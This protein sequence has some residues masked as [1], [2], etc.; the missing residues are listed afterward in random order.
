MNPPAWSSSARSSSTS[1]TSAGSAPRRASHVARSSAGTSSACSSR[2]LTSGQ[3]SRW[4]KKA[5]S[6]LRE[7]AEKEQLR[8]RP[9]ALDRGGGNSEDLADLLIV[10]AGEKP[11]LDDPRL[12]LVLA[13]QR[14][15]RLV[16][17]KDFEVPPLGQIEQRLDRQGPAALATLVPLAATGV[18]HEDHPHQLGG[19]AEKVRLVAPLHL[20][21]VHQPQIYLMHQSRGLERVP[22]ILSFEV[23]PRDPAQLFEDQ[24]HE[25]VQRRGIPFAPGQEQLGH[26]TFGIR[27][28]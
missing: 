4:L 24:R 10:E 22:G 1:A 26:L 23:A 11:H 8:R 12:P 19:E 7:L 27:H 25:P 5:S 14:L 3:R 6:T 2:D 9:L 16:D 18:V 17:E 13:R 21:T 15:Q 20:A 28:R